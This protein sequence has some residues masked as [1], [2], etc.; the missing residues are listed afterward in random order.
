MMNKGAIIFY[1]ISILIHSPIGAF[2]AFITGPRFI[3]TFIH[4]LLIFVSI[5]VIFL[6]VWHYLLVAGDFNFDY[7]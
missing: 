1:H 4:R 2:I 3:L 5:A 7:Y 6:A